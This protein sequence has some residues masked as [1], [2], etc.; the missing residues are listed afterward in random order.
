MPFV[1]I[2]TGCGPNNRWFQ[3][4]NS[5]NLPKPPVMAYRIGGFEENRQTSILSSASADGMAALA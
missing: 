4:K 2:G 1:A 5:K 3:A